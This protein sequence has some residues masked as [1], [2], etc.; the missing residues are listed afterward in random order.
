MPRGL[1]ILS[2]TKFILKKEM[3]FIEEL[4][5]SFHLGSDKNK[6]N[7]SKISVRKNIS[8]TSS[9]SNNAIQNA[10]QLSRVD[11]HNY[12]K[13][14]NDQD[15]I[16]IVKGTS[17]LYN[18]VKN[19]YVREFDKARIEYNERQ[20][21]DDRK[22]NDY[23]SH[24]SKN[25]KNDLAC[26]I[27]IELGNKQYWDTKDMNFKKKM[28]NVFTKQVEDLENLMPNFKVASA[29]IHYDE[30]SPHLHIVGVPIKTKNK[31]G[32]YKQVGKSNVFTKSSLETL[33]DK[34]RTLC[35]ESFN[36]EYKL[37]NT[38]KP[39]LKGRNQDIHVSDMVNYQKLQDELKKNKE[40]IEQAN[41]K[42]LELKD[43]SKDI[44][45]TINK[46][47]QSKLNKDNFILT[48]DEKESLIEY[49]DKVDK[50]N[51]DYNKLQPL[52]VSLNNANEQI[53]IL[54]DNNKALTIRNYELN[55][56][57]KEQEEN[58]EE[59]EEENFSLKSSLNSLKVKFKKLKKF[60]HEKLFGWGKKDPIYNQVVNDFYDRNILDDKDI[61]SIKKDS[62]EL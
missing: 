50:T 6:K 60:L 38:L 26:E 29:I 62:Y 36:Q 14:D 24:I 37:S 49:I 3:I 9:K 41:K 23:F 35:I 59:L 22:I 42:S 12:R 2:E 11:K 15:L 33:Q 53:K 8:G 28:T 45:D 30:T 20:T 44:K 31:N 19:L 46:L 51:N 57:V 34:M 40:Q 39:K 52:S 13:Y 5:Y 4:S 7:S 54:N 18:D 55:K 27:I 21:R 16:Q 17:S 47:K 1:H 48:A 32:M 10:N 61:D 25:E 43:N 58:I 56:K